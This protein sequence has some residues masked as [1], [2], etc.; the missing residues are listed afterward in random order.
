VKGPRFGSVHGALGPDWQTPEVFASG[1][2]PVATLQ[3]PRTSF[4]EVGATE[5]RGWLTPSEVGAA[6]RA[7]D[8]VLAGPRH[9]GCE[10]P[11]NTLVPLRWN[12][13]LVQLVLRS[14]QR[15]T[16]ITS[17]IDAQDLRWVSGYISMKPPN[18]AALWWH[19]DWWCWDHPV[20][21]RWEPTQVSVLCYLTDTDHRTGAFRYIPESHHTSTALHR[22]LPEAHDAPD[23]PDPSHVAF[24][25]QPG[26]GTFEARPGDALVTDYRLLHGTHPNTGA[27]TRSCL[28]LNFVP[29]WQGVPADIKAHL[30][31]GLGLPTAVERQ[32]L[33]KRHR[34]VFPDY[35]GPLHD[36]PLNRVPPGHWTS[37]PR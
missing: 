24:S 27:E 26:Q 35:D 21:F 37:R 12:S 30:I 19:Q 29:S 4:L 28:V 9:L 33:P 1:L 36:L 6:R 13:P 8:R 32:S 22:L 10:R 16:Q 15:L 25:D 2:E 17:A 31:Q 5:L 11:F 3:R 23:I 18:S 20:S 14:D 34:T 7:T